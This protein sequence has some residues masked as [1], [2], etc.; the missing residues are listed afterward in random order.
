MEK[1]ITFVIFPES[2]IQLWTPTIFEFDLHS[3]PAKW[4]DLAEGSLLRIDGKI[5]RVIKID[6]DS[7][8]T[9]IVVSLREWKA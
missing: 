7:S 6:H 9:F 3:R 2:E 4:A 5:T 8:A 1:K